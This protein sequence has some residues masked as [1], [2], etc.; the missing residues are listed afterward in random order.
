M[1]VH[2][3]WGWQHFCHP[4]A[5]PQSEKFW[6]ADVGQRLNFLNSHIDR[7]RQQAQNR[8]TPPPGLLRRGRRGQRAACHGW[9]DGCV[10]PVQR[11]AGIGVNAWSPFH[12]SDTPSSPGKRP[13]MARRP[14][15][16]ASERGAVQQWTMPNRLLPWRSPAVDWD[17]SPLVVT[18]SSSGLRLFNSS[19]GA[20]Q[21]W[22]TTIQVSLRGGPPVDC[23]KST[24]A[25]EQ[26]TAGLRQVNCCR[27][28]VHCWT[29]PNQLV[30]WRSPLLECDSA[31]LA[32]AQSTG[33]PRRVKS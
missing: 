33:G 23:D 30:T 13:R 24:L 15:R 10:R 4:L 5:L 19:H 21:Q 11:S 18:Q 32:V 3:G 22:T 29:A 25:V 28:A 31:T 7:P 16:F 12:P 1:D 6:S 14:P 2:L 17:T 27:D 8:E 20:V 9:M 26:S